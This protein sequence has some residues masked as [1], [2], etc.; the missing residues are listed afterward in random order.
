MK[1]TK[2]IKMKLVGNNPITDDDQKMFKLQID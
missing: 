1:Q 2:N